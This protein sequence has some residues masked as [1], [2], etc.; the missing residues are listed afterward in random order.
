MTAGTVDGSIGRDRRGAAARW[1]ALAAGAFLAEREQWA[2]WL[3]VAA[4]LGIALYFSLP[5]EPPGWAGPALA[6]LG[7]AAAW[8]GGRS[9]LTWFLSGWMLALAGLGFAAA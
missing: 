2:L 5:S 7:V 8:L 4:G 3:P 6:L 9:R 1:P